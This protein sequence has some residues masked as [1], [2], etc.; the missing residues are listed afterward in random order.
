[1]KKKLAS[2]TLYLMTAGYFLVSIYNLIFYGVDEN[3][4]WYQT[5][6]E[7][8]GT[9][10]YEEIF[11]IGIGSICINLLVALLLFIFI[12]RARVSDYCLA[13]MVWGLVLPAWYFTPGLLM[14][15]VLGAVVVTIF[16]LENLTSLGRRR[17]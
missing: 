5:L 12:G 13:A 10:E 7:A 11:T 14:K 16:S 15:Y 4:G 6:S 8:W 3:V 17:A 9:P 1:M 2:I